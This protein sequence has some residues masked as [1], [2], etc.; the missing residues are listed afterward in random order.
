MSWTLSAFADE[1]A[2]DT[3]G[4]IKALKE[5]GISHIDPRNVDG[6]NISAL[7]EELAKAVAEKYKAAGISVGMFGS[8]IGKITL[9]DDMQE[10]LDRLKHLAKLAPIFDCNQVRIFSYYTGEGNDISAAEFE[11]E[12]ISRLK[13]L[14][15]L[16]ADLG[17]VL[18]HE[19]ER[20]IFGDTC[21]QV[22]AIADALHDG[23]TFKLI[24]DFDNYNQSGDDVWANWE[25]LRSRTD[26]FHLKD[27][28][29]NNMHVPIGQGAGHAKK[30]LKD[31]QDRGWSG[32]LSL[33]PHL[34]R[35][36]AVMATGPSG[37]ANQALKDM[38]AEE[39]FQVAAA[40]AKELLS[41]VGATVK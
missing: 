39:V 14:K 40:T 6:H 20:H 7:P 23:K 41:E 22:E 34:K 35:S 21:K 10:D 31:A 33:E 12:S 30:I 28:D 24:F 5:A 1:S 18:F 2:G 17:M 37:V 26:A 3:D 29:E 11:K 8:P 19:N 38:S 16:A 13:E 27:S 32:Q 9:L 36:E 4:Q 25:R 15:S